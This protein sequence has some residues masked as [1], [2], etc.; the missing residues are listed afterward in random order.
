MITALSSSIDN[1][2]KPQQ[3]KD[4]LSN[5][6]L[7]AASYS[8]EIGT[9]IIEIAPKVGTVLWA[10]AL[11]YLGADIFDKYKNDQNKF[12]P[13]AKRAFERTIYQGISNY[14]CMP[15]LI[16]CAQNLVSP[17]AR[18]TK[19]GISTNA[20][21]AVFKH[22][23]EILSQ[24]EGENFE[25]PEKFKSVI[26]STLRARIKNYT[27][28]KNNTN[29]FKRI[30]KFSLTKSALTS[31]NEDKIIKFA[32]KNTDKMFELKNNLINGDYDKVPQMIKKDYLNSVS[33]L[34]LFGETNVNPALRSALK[35]YQNMNIFNNK[36]LKT[37]GGF[38]PIIF[39]STPVS[40]FVEKVIV[41]KYLD[42]GLD[43]IT[44]GFVHNTRFKSLF[45]EMDKKNTENAEKAKNEHAADAVKQ[46]LPSA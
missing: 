11:M 32:I 24:C 35:K 25:N 3:Y 2:N 22:T 30:L 39:L 14:L 1:I 28:E 42:Q 44:K 34:K 38:I 7:V 17:L 43:E 41:D 46:E 31:N 40:R 4:P 33:G 10:P 9:A 45:N 26:E 20:K 13:S 8:N 6:L 21:D 27:H 23:R 15:L 16:F 37:I 5:P 12:D 36:I 29:I 19:D 18:F